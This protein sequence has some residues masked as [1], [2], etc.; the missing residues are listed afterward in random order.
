MRIS[1]RAFVE[2]F[3][4][5]GKRY[6]FQYSALTERPNA[7]FLKR[8]LCSEVERLQIVGFEKRPIVDQAKLF[9]KRDRRQAATVKRV[10]GDSLDARRNDVIACSTLWKAIKRSAVVG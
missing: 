2:R 5:I 10:W 1:E 6:A 4:R 8:R 9:V 3:E 7:D